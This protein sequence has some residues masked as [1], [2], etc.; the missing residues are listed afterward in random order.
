MRAYYFRKLSCYV[1]FILFSIMVLFAPLAFAIANSDE[2]TWFIGAGAGMSWEHLTADSTQVVNGLPYP[3]P[4]N[5]DH[6]SIH[7]LDNGNLQLD[8]GYR[9]VD[10]QCSYFPYIHAF[11]QYRSYINNDIKGTIE[12]FSLPEFTNYH[13]KMAY[14]ADLLTINGKFDIVDYK[15]FMPYLLIG[16]GVVFN[17]VYDYTEEPTANVTPRVSPG[18]RTNRNTQL[19]LVLG[20]GIDYNVTE[21]AWISLG[22]EHVF[23]GSVKSGSGQSSWAGT[24]LDFGNVKM[25]TIYINFTINFPK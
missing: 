5:Y 20:T 24:R 15:H 16:G 13:Y 22:Y 25:D 6:Y 8:I 9:F 1:Y 18:Y 3:Y 21:N 4:S 12:Q 19:A 2:N 17:S 10:R 7:D 23:Q 11:L 14:T